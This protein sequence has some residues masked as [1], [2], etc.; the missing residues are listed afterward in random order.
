MSAGRVRVRHW[1]FT[2][3]ELLV[4]IAIIAVLIG[5]LL[6][7]VQ[8]VR[9]A[10][11][12]IQSASNLKQIGLA[13]HN[14]ADTNN[15]R[16]PGAYNGKWSAAPLQPTTN[17]QNAPYSNLDGGI[18]VALLPYLEQDNVYRSCQDPVTGIVFP[19]T[20]GTSG[21]GSLPLKVLVAPADS[22]SNNG[23]FTN[24]NALAVGVTNYLSN[25][26]AL[27]TFYNFGTGS[28][29]EARGA[30]AF[31]AF[32]SDGTS[33]TIVFAEGTAAY[34]H[35]GSSGSFPPSGRLWAGVFPN[36]ALTASSF[37][38]PLGTLDVRP[39]PRVRAQDADYNRPQTLASGVRG[40]PLRLSVRAV[41]PSISVPTWIAACTPD[42]GDLLG[43]DW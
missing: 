26:V 10:A 35:N 43:S 40:V 29:Q 15:G 32:V 42:A 33:N 5:L 41:G 36:G 21:P 37:I 39:Q 16:L 9:A 8:K 11:A 13:L 23:T 31:P 38:T 4:V 3:I 14:C 27:D 20:G 28:A 22:T 30:R 6:P 2:L 25:E 12:R 7:A 34:G 19:W 18:H 24:P 1:G 17:P